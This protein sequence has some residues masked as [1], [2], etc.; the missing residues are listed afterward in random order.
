MDLIYL[1]PHQVE[2]FTNLRLKPLEQE[3][4]QLKLILKI[5]L[6]SLFYLL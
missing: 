4:N 1:K 2:I 6:K 3:V 5:I